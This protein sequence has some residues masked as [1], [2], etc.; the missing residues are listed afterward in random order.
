M[1][2]H[3]FKK[4]MPSDFFFFDGDFWAFNPDVHEDEVEGNVDWKGGNLPYIKSK[5]SLPLLPLDAT[6][7]KLLKNPWKSA[8]P[9]GATQNQPSTYNPVP[10]TRSPAFTQQ[11]P[12][13]PHLA[14]GYAQD[15]AKQKD[16]P[17]VRAYSFRGDTRKPDELKTAGG[18]S[19]PITRTDD[20]Y[21][22]NV[23]YKQFSAYLKDKRGLDISYDDFDKGMKK[24]LVDQSMKTAL[25]YYGV[26]RAIVEQ[27]SL[28]VG[29]MLAE[30][31][32]KGFVSTTKA[33]TVA[34]G[35]A[36]PGGWIYALFL[37]GG[38]LVPDKGAHDWTAI[39]GEQEIAMPVPIQWKDVCGFRQV[40]NDKKF[41]G[42]VYLR[43]D[44][45]DDDAMLKCHSLLS[46]KKQA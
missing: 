28:H 33:T 45:E 24:T 35:F 21:M 30:E 44:I 31:A 16:I 22:K 43:P 17:R 2:E 26:W 10:V 7:E 32:L 3:L 42:P 46:G 27:E 5:S 20:Y 4:R 14:T 36:K 19:P 34:K 37:D 38:Y 1:H 25:I 29:R 8:T 12:K 13:A 15:W 11:V 18:F 9:K 41:I 23:V 40:G 39:F 6:L